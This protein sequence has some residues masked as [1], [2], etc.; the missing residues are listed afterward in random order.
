MISNA[1]SS[2]PFGA[3]TVSRMRSCTQRSRRVVMSPPA[4]PGAVILGLYGA[5]VKA[6]IA[7]TASLRYRHACGCSTPLP[8]LGA[9][10]TLYM[11]SSKDSGMSPP[12]FADSA[13]NCRSISPTSLVKGLSSN[14]AEPSTSASRNPTTFARQS[15]TGG[16]FCVSGSTS[17]K[18]LKK[19]MTFFLSLSMQFPML[20]VASIKNTMS[21][22]PFTFSC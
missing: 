21:T 1:A 15:L 20:P 18:L 4:I 13:L 10:A 12:S 19:S 6:I 22:T 14:H 3:T 16:K 11:A 17:V 9:S 7:R 2:T 5:S 8:D